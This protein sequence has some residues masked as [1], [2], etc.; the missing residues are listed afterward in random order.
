VF[1]L[2]LTDDDVRIQIQ[3]DDI[4]HFVNKQR[5]VRQCERVDAIRLQRKRLPNARHA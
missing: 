1:T 5:I 4:P 3:P 2:I